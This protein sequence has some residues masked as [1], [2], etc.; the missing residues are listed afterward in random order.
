MTDSVKIKKQIRHL[1]KQAR[2]QGFVSELEIREIAATPEDERYLTETLKGS[3][4]EINPFV[5]RSKRLKQVEQDRPIP[6]IHDQKKND[7][8]WNYLNHVGSFP[9]LNRNQEIE[10]ARQ[11]VLGKNKLL[12]SGFRSPVI[13]EYLVRL[14]DELQNGVLSCDD[15]LDVERSEEDVDSVDEL[16]DNFL[17]GVEKILEYQDRISEIRESVRSLSGSERVDSVE[18]VRDLT[19]LLVE[20]AFMLSIN[21]RQQ[22]T[23]IEKYG[24]WLKENSLDGE[25]ENF[26]SWE[27]IY[28]DAKDSVIESNYRLVISIAKKYKFTGMELIDVI[29]EGNRG[30]MKAVDHFDYRKGYKFS[31]YATW[32][33]RQAITRAINDKGKAIR[34]PA[35][36]REL[37]NRVV[38][39][40]QRFV[41]EHGYEPAAHEIADTLTISERKVNQILNFT[42]DPVSL[43]RELNDGSDSTMADFVADTTAENPSDT[44]VIQGLRD[45]LDSLL[46]GLGTKERR[47]IMMRY[48]YD[49]GR[50]KTLNE[51]GDI[52]GIS[53]ERVRQIEVRALAK[54]RHPGRGSLLDDWRFD[55][56]ELEEFSD[57]ESHLG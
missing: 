42:M 23:I 44:V 46:K 14:S 12:E 20:T 11:M 21:E 8:I 53:R 43:D 18:N 37:M 56:D 47:V 50:K 7:P 25:L 13:Q 5:A 55:Q 24:T 22:K 16:Y 32:W 30:L 39:Y 41:L 29:Q 48:G 54:L 33:I 49:D 35:N 9:L 2:L 26:Y 28:S 31:T 17:V 52:F 1:E 15:V 27:K 51:I 19:D 57:F 38:R 6:D 40:S 10:Y 45:S 3:G 34:I 36:T 4:F